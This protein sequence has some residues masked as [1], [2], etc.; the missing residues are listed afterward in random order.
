M[1]LVPETKRHTHGD[2]GGGGRGEGGVTMILLICDTMSLLHKVGRNHLT[3]KV[4][5]C[6]T[7][8]NKRN[9][10]S[11]KI[12]ARWITI[13]TVAPTLVR[14]TRWIIIVRV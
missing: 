9:S 6:S 13:D 7:G 10:S 1:Y 4:L 14:Y 2:I 3:H 8:L 5:H 11:T 12:P